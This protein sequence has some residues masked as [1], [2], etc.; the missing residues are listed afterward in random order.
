MHYSLFTIHLQCGDS[1]QQGLGVFCL[2]AVEHIIGRAVFHNAAA[3]HHGD[4]IRQIMHHAEVVRDENHGD[5]H[6]FHQ[7][8]EQVENLAL[9]RDIEC[10]DRFIRQQQSRARRY[11]AGNGDALTLAAG[12]LMRVLIHVLRAEPHALHEL[13]HS[14]LTTAAGER[15]ALPQ[16]LGQGGEDTEARVKRSIGVLEHHLEIQTAAAHLARRQGCEVCAI[17]HNAPTRHRLKLH[18]GPGKGR[19]TAAALAHQAKDA[20]TSDREAHIIHRAHHLTSG[21]PGIAHREMHTH[22]LQLQICHAEAL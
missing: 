19:L 14:I 6:I 1:S 5:S 9:D 3:A 2:R 17:Q 20:P 4:I 22:M 8:G 11:G 10:R 18:D 21:A 15:L 7:I 12:K 16:R 13:G